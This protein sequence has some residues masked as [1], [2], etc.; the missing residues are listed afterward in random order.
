DDL[1]TQGV[2][3]VG[4]LLPERNDLVS[5]QLVGALEKPAELGEGRR[6]RKRA[7]GP[8]VLQAL[9]VDAAQRAAVRQAQAVGLADRKGVCVHS[10]VWSSKL[11]A[12]RSRFSVVNPSGPS[13]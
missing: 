10:P 7:F 6:G 13:G 9:N 3:G 2:N 1:D 5:R 11:C 4:R 12:S 8:S